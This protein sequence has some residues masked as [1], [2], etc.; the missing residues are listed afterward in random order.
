M[1]HAGSIG[2]LP[3]SRRVNAMRVARSLQMRSLFPCTAPATAN[4][5]FQLHDCVGIQPGLLGLGSGSQL[6]VLNVLQ[7]IADVLQRM[8]HLFPECPVLRRRI[9]CSETDLQ[10]V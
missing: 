1:I 4:I 8:D 5:P 9:S 7:R 6:H 10:I 2:I 3:G